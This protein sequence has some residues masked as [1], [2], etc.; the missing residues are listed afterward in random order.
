[1]KKLPASRSCVGGEVRPPV[2]P[3]RRNSL[4]VR[5]SRGM[6]LGRLRQ[7]ATSRV[8][9]A[10]CSLALGV[11]IASCGAIATASCETHDKLSTTAAQ[12]LMAPN[13][14]R[15]RVRRMATSGAYFGGQRISIVYV[16]QPVFGPIDIGHI[17]LVVTN[18]DGSQGTLGFYSKGYRAGGLPMMLPD[19][20]ILVTP[21]PLYARASEDPDLSRKIRVLWTGELSDSQAEVLNSWLSSVH[22]LS[23]F[24]TRKGE[25]R[26]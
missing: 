12:R 6:L 8:A 10:G 24:T 16:P 23:T 9:R 19:E 26:E 15:R 7:L 21:D 3:S 13:H 4:V 11:G 2:H 17:S 20:G 1:M 14:G 25:E 22:A 5:R 18:H